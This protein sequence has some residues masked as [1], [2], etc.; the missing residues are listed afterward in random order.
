MQ[1]LTKAVIVWLM[2]MLM[3]IFLCFY[4]ES[5]NYFQQIIT[6]DA[7]ERANVM[8]ISQVIY[9][10]APTLTNLLIPMIAGW[11]W[12]LDNI[13]TYR[14]IYPI[15]TVIGLVMS[16]IF[17]RKV[18]ERLIL[19]KKK[20][21]PVRMLD[22]IREIAKNK[23]YWIIHAAA[24]VVFLESGYGVVLSWSFVCGH[25]GQ[26]QASLGLAN[27]VIGNPINTPQGTT[28][29]PVSKVSLGFASGG[30]DYAGK[31]EEAI[32]ARIQN[33]GGGGGT[34]LSVVPVG[35][36]VVSPNGD[37]DMINVGMEYKSGPIEQVADVIERTPEIIAKIKS[38]FSKDE[39]EVDTEEEA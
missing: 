34:G 21:E 25:G 33:F 7:Q 27:T 39:A 26:Y 17:F 13:W 29:I 28:I 12:G 22:A 19:P 4:S 16:L 36:L 15:F 9:S 37:V 38:F 2:Y 30:L 1:Y 18:K 24:W 11:T 20:P 32:R 6:P 31:S 3:N 5:Y 14:I 23:Y 35:F 8:S 10:L